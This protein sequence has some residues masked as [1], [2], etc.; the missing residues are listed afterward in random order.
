MNHSWIARIQ[1]GDVLRS[2]TGLLRVVREVSHAEVCYSGPPHIRTSVVFAIKHCSWTRRPYTVYTGN[3][4]A[5][6]GYRPTRARVSL[7]KRIDLAIMR[8]YAAKPKWG[9]KKPY[10]ITC[11]DVEGI[12]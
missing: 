6:M 8:V 4:L 12:A 11:C 5:R 7:R 1:K 10:E 3:D 2:R 9:A